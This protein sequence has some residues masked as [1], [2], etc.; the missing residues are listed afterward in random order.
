MTGFRDEAGGQ[1]GRHV[2]RMD[3]DVPVPVLVQAMV[4]AESSGV[5]FTASALRIIG[6]ELIGVEHLKH[7]PV[8]PS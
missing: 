8:P 3:R 4:A 5:A 7:Q 6:A 2:P 1:A